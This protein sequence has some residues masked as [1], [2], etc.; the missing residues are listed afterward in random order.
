MR[1]TAS[2]YP[3][4]R[5]VKIESA[6]GDRIQI[7]EL[8]V[9]SSENGN[10]ALNKTAS[11]SST[12]GTKSAAFALDGDVT[13][14]SQTY[15]TDAWW[16]VDLG[17]TFLVKSVIIE[18]KWCEESHDPNGC[19]CKLSEATLS[20]LNDDGDVVSAEVIGNKCSVRDCSFDMSSCSQAA[21]NDLPARLVT[22]HSRKR[23][24][25]RKRPT[26]S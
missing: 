23:K 15:D 1:S 26:R 11:Q 22:K 10:I 8:K 18:N 9:L 14:S 6:A 3:Q 4:A 20:L 2:C 24:P 16:E 21:A 25:R 7:F 17:N 19:L 12:F 5:K 13:T